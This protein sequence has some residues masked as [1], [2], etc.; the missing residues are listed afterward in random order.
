MYFIPIYFFIR[1]LFYYI[2]FT[3]RSCTLER[4]TKKNMF[5]YNN[6]SHAC[7]VQYVT[8]KMEP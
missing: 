1:I 6:A 2:L 3:Y 4:D 7:N 5:Y 8:N